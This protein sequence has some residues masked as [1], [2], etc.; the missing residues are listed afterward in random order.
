MHKVL[1]GKVYYE[2]ICHQRQTIGT[3]RGLAYG[4]TESLAESYQLNS[5]GHFSLFLPL[6]IFR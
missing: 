3:E 1:Q 4:V 2:H 6:E 5:M